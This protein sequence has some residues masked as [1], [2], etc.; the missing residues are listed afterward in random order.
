MTASAASAKNAG[1]NPPAMSRTAPTAQGPTNPPKYPSPMI[2][3]PAWP[4]FSAGIARAMA[5]LVIEALRDFGV[6]R[7]DVLAYGTEEDFCAELGFQKL[8]GVVPMEL[9]IT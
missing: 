4:A 5:T 9:C 3:P 1:P 8:G 7:I 6:E 2:T